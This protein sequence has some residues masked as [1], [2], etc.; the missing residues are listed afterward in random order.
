M[1]LLSGRATDDARARK[2]AKG[3]GQL[4]QEFEDGRERR[5]PLRLLQLEEDGEGTDT[6]YLSARAKEGGRESIYKRGHGRAG[7]CW[8]WVAFSE[9][10]TAGGR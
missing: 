6:T 4:G 9:G 3:E 10:N 5:P 8:G 1:G 7:G 2:H